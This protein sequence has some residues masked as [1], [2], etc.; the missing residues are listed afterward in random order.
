MLQ[1]YIVVR[2]TSSK[3]TFEHSRI[4]DSIHLCNS[5]IYTNIIHHSYDVLLYLDKAWNALSGHH[6][7]SSNWPEA[8]Q[9][10]HR[11][12]D[13]ILLDQSY[14]LKYQDSYVVWVHYAIISI[15]SSW[16]VHNHLSL[17][18]IMLD[19]SFCILW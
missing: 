14:M 7:N 5:S 8:H 6:V 4:K 11:Q 16:L 2:S 10:T 18:F 12:D 1:L 19:T 3:S 9:Q 15:V 17:F 13:I